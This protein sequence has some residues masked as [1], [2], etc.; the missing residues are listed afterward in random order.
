M[1]GQMCIIRPMTGITRY[2]L[3]Q[4]TVGMIFVSAALACVIWLTQSLRFVEMI[5]NK[6]LSLGTFL[7]LTLLLMPSFLVVIVPISLFAVV[8][9]TYNKLTSDRELVVMRS[10]GLSHWALARPALILGL[11]S[12]VLS[13]ALSLWIIPRTMESFHE[14]QWAI[15]NDISG[16]LLQEGSFNKFGDGVTVYVRSR[17]SDGELLGLLVHDRRIPAKPV[18][19][20]AERGALVYTDAGP[21]IL[22]VNGNRQQLER[23]SGKLS[24]LYFD[25]YTVD[26]AIATGSNGAR[27]RDA[28]EQPLSFLLTATEGKLGPAEYRRAKVEL[29][30]RFTSPLYNLGFV[31]VALAALLPASFNRRGQGAQ[32]LASIGV[33]VVMEA[34]SLGTS[35]LATASL[36]FTPAMYA[37]ALAPIAIGAWVLNGGHGWRRSRSPLPASA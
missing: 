23:D 9:F 10:A 15:R 19:M 29:H 30:Q 26:F 1:P 35:N 12:T 2:V 14:M 16:L 8:L 17:S 34:L 33:M 11:A 32:I 31:I 20:V 28:R 25:S 18:T 22:M 3:R 13:F 5:V 21:R 36:A 7:S 27:S 6:G 4:L 24:L 37:A